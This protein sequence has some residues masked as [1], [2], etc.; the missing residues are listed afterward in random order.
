MYLILSHYAIYTFEFLSKNPHFSASGKQLLVAAAI[1]LTK[2]NKPTNCGPNLQP[3]DIYKI[4]PT[5]VPPALK[6]SSPAAQ[7]EQNNPMLY[8]HLAH[9]RPTI[10]SALL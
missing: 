6:T 7:H 8:E 5:Y 1:V 4:K 2:F 3:K 9:H 10:A